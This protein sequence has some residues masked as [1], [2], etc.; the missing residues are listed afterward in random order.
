MTC[1][2]DASSMIARYIGLFIAIAA[3]DLPS[4]PWHPAQF[5]AYKVA[6]SVTSEGR[7]GRSAC[8]GR[9]GSESHPATS[10]AATDRLVR[11]DFSLRAFNLV[12]VLALLAEAG[13]FDSGADGKRQMLHRTHA[14]GQVDHV[15]RDCAEGDLAQDEPSP[16]DARVE[17][18]IDN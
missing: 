2:I 5:S 11:S 6:K 1:R 16:L 8:V 12:L 7:S 10:T 3:P 15:T 18:R 17:Q 13:R 9:P 4:A 14:L